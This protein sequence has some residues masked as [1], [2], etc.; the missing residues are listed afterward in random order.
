MRINE[1]TGKDPKIKSVKPGIEAE[2]DNG[3]G[4]STVVDLKQN[5]SALTKTDDGDVKLN[6]SQQGDPAPE[7]KLKPGEKVVIDDEGK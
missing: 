1:I 6:K 3:D 5:P 2:I 4:T 7:R